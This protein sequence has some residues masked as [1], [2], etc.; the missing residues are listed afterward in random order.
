[1][2]DSEGAHRWM[3]VFDELRARGV[4]DVLYVSSDGVAGLGEGA[5]VRVP[6]GGAPALR[7]PPGP[8]LAEVRP[9]EGGRGVLPLRARGLRRALAGGRRVG[10]GGLPRGVVALPGC[11]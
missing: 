9:A 7:R 5:R 1:M 2:D 10:L 8:Q 11:I 6:A 3:Q 4:E